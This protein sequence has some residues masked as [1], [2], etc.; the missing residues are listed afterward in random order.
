MFRKKTQE[1]FDVL[2]TMQEDRMAYSASL[3]CHE[4]CVNNYWLNHLYLWERSCMTNC[5]EKLNQVTV[6]TN[7]NY[8]KFEE[9]GGK[10]K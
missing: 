7:I 6:V 1:E 8:G 3:A 10:M 2:Q 9:D 5:L 4:R